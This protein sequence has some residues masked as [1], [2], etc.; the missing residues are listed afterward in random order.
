MM[1]K[2][3]RVE[4]ELSGR[5]LAM[6]IVLGATLT[7]AVIS[8]PLAFACQTYYSSSDNYHHHDDDSGGAATCNGNSSHSRANDGEDFWMADGNDESHG[9]GE[10]DNMRMGTGADRAYGGDYKDDLHLRSEGD[11]G[12]GGGGADRLYGGWGADTLIAGTHPDRLEDDASD[13]IYEKD[14]LRGECGGD[15]IMTTQDGD[16]EDTIH[17]SAGDSVFRDQNLNGGNDVLTWHSC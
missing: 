7:A 16:T 13:S 17:Y 9:Y 11:H 1:L 8:G 12:E 6:V 5:L 15:D 4:V 2:R 14:T 3:N 10:F